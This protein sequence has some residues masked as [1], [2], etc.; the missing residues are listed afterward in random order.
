MS[1]HRRHV[2]LV[3]VVLALTAPATATPAPDVL[4]PGKVTVVHFFASWCSPCV[5]A[6]PALDGV[7]KRH[8]GSVAVV[9]FGEDDDE[10]SMKAFV[11]RLGISYPARWD[12]NKAQ[13]TRWHVNA[14][15]STF[16]IDK[17]GALRFTHA[18]FNDADAATYETEVS[19]L[20]AE[21]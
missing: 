1:L 20:N 14:M 9:A 8:G 18:G 16:I 10:P 15:P 19:A 17:H 3:A 2:M 6:M 5:R 12:G 11:T 7:Y 13:A 21:H 4:A